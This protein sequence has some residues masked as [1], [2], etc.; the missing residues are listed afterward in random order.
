M[1]GTQHPALPFALAGDAG[2][3]AGLRGDCAAP[4]GHKA[5]CCH[6]GPAAE[7]RRAAVAGRPC[8]RFAGSCYTKAAVILFINSNLPLEH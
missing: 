4:A 8:F 3:S 2:S 5:T 6:P 7:R 1:G